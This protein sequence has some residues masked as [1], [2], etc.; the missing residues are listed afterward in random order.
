MLNQCLTVYKL[1][2]SFIYRPSN[3]SQSLHYVLLWSAFSMRDLSSRKQLQ[4]KRHIQRHQQQQFLNGI[5]S[6]KKKALRLFDVFLYVHP[7]HF[8]NSCSMK[9]L[10]L[11]FLINNIGSMIN[12]GLGWK[13]LKM[14][15]DLGNGQWSKSRIFIQEKY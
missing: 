6:K 11:Y 14:S 1:V 5:T 13:N 3:K 4:H 7:L 12:C 8:H 9:S 2:T 10:L 15:K